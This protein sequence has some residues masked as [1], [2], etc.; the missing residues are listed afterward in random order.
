VRI[1]F[2]LVVNV[3]YFTTFCWSRDIHVGDDRLHIVSF[4]KNVE[5]RNDKKT[6]TFLL[7]I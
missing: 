7:F 2:D 6:L 1:V 4:R 3:I 5:F